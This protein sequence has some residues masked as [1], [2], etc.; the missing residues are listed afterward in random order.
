MRRLQEV[1]KE[2]ESKLGTMVKKLLDQKNDFEDLLKEKDK[3]ISKL[4][5]ELE[6]SRLSLSE[7]K[8]SLKILI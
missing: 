5:R 6:E 1:N 2:P 8:E 3:L 7:L 4:Q